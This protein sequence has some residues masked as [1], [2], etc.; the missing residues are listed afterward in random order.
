MTRPQLK[1]I[2]S[3]PDI[4]VLAAV[5]L[6]N[7][8]S[9]LFA[10][11]RNPQIPDKVEIRYQRQQSA[12]SLTNA[13]QRLKAET[14]AMDYYMYVHNVTDEGFHLV[15]KYN[16]TLQQER[17]L[18]QRA[19]KRPSATRQAERRY[20]KAKDR[21]MTAVKM[22]YGYWKAGHFYRGKLSGYG[23]TRDYQGRIVSALWDN[24]TIVSAI[25]TDSTGIYRGQMDKYYL[26]CGEGTMDEWN[27][28]HKEGFWKDDALHGFGFDSSPTHQLRIGEW[29]HGRFLGERM[30]Y[31]SERI[32]GIDISRH[33]HEKGRRRFNILW[34]KVRITSL[35]K[36]HNTEG[37]TYPVSFVYIKSTEGTTIRNRYF[38]KDYMAARANGIRTGAYHFFSLKSPAL[39]QATYFVNHTLFRDGDFPPVL[40]VEPTDAQIKSIGGDEVL[41]KRIRVF[42]EYVEK[43]T[44]MRPILYVSQMFIN[45][46]MK[47]AADIK[48]NY[49][50]WI[51]RYGQYKPDVKL[52]FWQLCPDGRVDGITGDVDIN[53]FNGYQVQFDNF[54]RTGFHK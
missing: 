52:V 10:P 27:G 7:P 4:M 9:P 39:E 41:M 14:D 40:D 32:Y 16:N 29:K 31:T 43:R 25:R 12:D 26:A 13:M 28:C 38:L 44:H 45:R 37:R 17:L 33:Q 2:A 53:V 36:R 24:D 54:I 8:L 19:M 21:P 34:N 1:A 11:K 15:A 22:G 35:G 48:Q 49:N 42:M 3:L 47:E 50:V 20:V 18:L 6:L 46:H 23:I 5:V 30:R 51:A